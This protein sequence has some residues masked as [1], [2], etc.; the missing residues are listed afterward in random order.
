MFCC[1]DEFGVFLV[2]LLSCYKVL[3]QNC[4]PKDCID[5]KCYRVSTATNGA[6]IY[7]DSTPFSKV[8]VTCDQTT[9]GGGWIIYLQRF[10]GSIA[11]NNTWAQYKDGFGEQGENSEFW[12]GNENVYQ[13]VKNFKGGNAQLRIEV[14]QFDGSS[15]SFY[16]N[17]FRLENEADGY[18]LQHGSFNSSGSVLFGLDMYWFGL[19]YLHTEHEF[20]TVDRKLKTGNTSHKLIHGGWWYGDEWLSLY[21]T[22]RY[23]GHFANDSMFACGCNLT[24]AKKRS[25]KTAYMMFRPKERDRPCRNPCNTGTCEH[26][27][28]SNTYRCVCPRTHCGPM[29]EANPCNN[30]GSC[31]YNSKTK[32]LLCMCVGSFT[33]TYCNE[34]VTK[35][36]NKT[37]TAQTKVTET[38]KATATTQKQLKQQKYL[39]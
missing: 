18:R 34:T 8:K 25:V 21:L 28:K 31:L 17:D 4:K 15:C 5:L 13:L 16:A 33:G 36:K 24:D 37:I 20:W 26:L 6:V 1:C 14:N 32:K 30:H 22:G 38:T 19:H 2:V 29:C 12:L 9:D 23:G 39:F 10:D 3:G 11:F 7:T 35:Q 27:E